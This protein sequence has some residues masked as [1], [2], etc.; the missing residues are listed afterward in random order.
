MKKGALIFWIAVGAIVVAGIAAAFFVKSGPSNL[1]P[2]AA[3]IKEKGIVFYGAFWCPHCQ[4]TKAMFGSAA[5]SLPYV[6]CSTADGKAQT[7][8]CIDK[9]I[10]SYPTWMKPDGTSI[11]G[12]HSLKEIAEFT[13]CA[14]P[15]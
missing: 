13:G 4:R 11:T 5:K 7:Q 1:E 15:Q 3:C 6:E 12:E 9:K 2:F 10:Q 8:I 14:L